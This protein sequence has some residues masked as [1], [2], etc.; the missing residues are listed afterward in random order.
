MQR[1]RTA[2][3]RTAALG[4]TVGLC[5]LIPLA[6]A[7]ADG[8]HD[9]APGKVQVADGTS[10]A[11]AKPKPSG[12]HDF[13]NGVD[14]SAPDSVEAV[15]QLLGATTTPSGKAP[16]ATSPTA[17]PAAAT[18]PVSNALCGKAVEA[19]G[20]VRAQ[21][22]VE[23]EGS[24]VWGRVYYRNTTAEPLLLVLSLLR[25]DSGTVE[26]RC[27]V[28]AKSGDAVCETPRLR[29]DVPL[30]EWSAIAE[31]ATA[32]EAEKVLRAGTASAAG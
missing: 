26:M 2:R 16:A 19:P 4:T 27:E 24:E 20:G 22:C 12:P 6:A 31:V 9:K 29:T 18:T 7:S 14:P 10:S 25:P 8:S 13:G 1:A 28:A 5:L 32:D 11:T 3:V 17:S 15:K 23:R 30:A 21:T